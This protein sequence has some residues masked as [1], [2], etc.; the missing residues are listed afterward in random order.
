MVLN[1]TIDFMFIAEYKHHCPPARI[2]ERPSLWAIKDKPRG[3]AGKK[4]SV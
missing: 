4:S 1:I 2:I 3:L